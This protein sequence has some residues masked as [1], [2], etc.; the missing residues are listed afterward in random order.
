MADDVF[1]KIIR[2]EL[3]HDEDKMVVRDSDFIV[4][5]DIHPQ[6]PVH[7]LII[8]VRH[9][10]SLSD[11]KEEDANLLGKAMIM[12]DKVANQLGLGKGYRLILNKGEDGGQVV[13]HLHIHLLGGKKLGPKVV[14]D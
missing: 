4:I 11:F 2:G 9:F 1:C 3:R 10:D 12:A 5:H 8:P 6:A 13:P 14:R 7:L